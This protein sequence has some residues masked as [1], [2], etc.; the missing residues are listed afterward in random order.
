MKTE[1]EGSVICMKGQF[2]FEYKYQ[3][4]FYAWQ[5]VANLGTYQ[6]V[7]FVPSIIFWTV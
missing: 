4:F 6:R 2:I 5:F 7:Y 3:Q 1:A